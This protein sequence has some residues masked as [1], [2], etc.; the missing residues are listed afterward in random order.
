MEDDVELLAKCIQLDL[1]CAAICNATAQMMSLGGSRSKDLCFICSDICEACAKECLKH[2]YE[3]CK[4]C[5][6]A[7]KRCEELC[8]EIN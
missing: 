1:E 2:N 7:C 3:Y 4:E 8:T 5:A 6:K